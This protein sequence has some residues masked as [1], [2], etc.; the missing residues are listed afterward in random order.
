M[1]PERLREVIPVAAITGQLLHR[2]WL[3]SGRPDPLIDADAWDG[4]ALTIAAVARMER[5]TTTGE[6]SCGSFVPDTSGDAG[7][8]NCGADYPPGEPGEP[9]ETE[10]G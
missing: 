8:G 2:A 7:C 4:F 1:T 3:K 9:K 10:R 6:C 5:I